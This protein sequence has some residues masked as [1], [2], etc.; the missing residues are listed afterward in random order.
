LVLSE[1]ALLAAAIGDGGLTQA[2][3]AQLVDGQVP[4]LASGDSHERILGETAV[5]KF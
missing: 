2:A 1:Q 5:P 4:A 3:L